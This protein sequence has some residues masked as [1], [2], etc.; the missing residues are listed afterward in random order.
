[1]EYSGYLEKIAKCNRYD[2]EEKI[3]FLVDGKRVGEVKK[4]YLSYLLQSGVFVQKSGYITLHE[5]LESFETRTEALMKFA[6]NAL[7]DGITDSFMNEPYAVLENP[8][9]KPCCLADRAISSL[10]GLIAF[11]QHLNGFVRTKEGL[12]MWIGK[13]S[14]NKGHEPGKLDHLVAGGLPYNISLRKNLEKECYEEAGISPELAQKAIPVGFVSYKVDYIRGSNRD[15]IY[16][17]DLE[18]PESFVPRCT[19]GEVEVFYLMKIEEVAQLVRETDAFKQNCNLVI[20]EFLVR[21]GY[22]EPEKAGYVEI[23]DGLRKGNFSY[24]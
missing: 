14:Y 20:I 13:R 7:K 8:S 10:L 6:E 16:C 15:I 12:K 19:D 24:S 1:M 23:V 21:H 17:Y 11:G 22:L 2:D 18:L 5:R 3:P 4:A 9:A